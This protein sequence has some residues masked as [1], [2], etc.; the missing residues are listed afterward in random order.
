MYYSPLLFHYYLLEHQRV[1]HLDIS[2]TLTLYIYLYMADHA[3]STFILSRL[4]RPLVLLPSE[5]CINEIR[6]I[7]A[8]FL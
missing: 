1:V 7:L 4:L 5:I 2:F 8:A 3:G 6:M